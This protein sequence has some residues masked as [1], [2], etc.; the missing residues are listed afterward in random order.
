M[1]ESGM[2]TPLIIAGS[3]DLYR[4]DLV[5]LAV[6]DWLLEHRPVSEVIS[7]GA[8]GTDATGE[9]WAAA[10]GY[11][12]RRFPAD[13]HRYGRTAGLRRNRQMAEYAAQ[14]GGGCLVIHHGSLDMIRTAQALWLP[15]LEWNLQGLEPG[16]F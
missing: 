8:K 10:G 11:P 12:V 4:P 14:H 16:E 1:P 3:R 7:G 13:W 15:V 6:Q 9:A 5:S 2:A